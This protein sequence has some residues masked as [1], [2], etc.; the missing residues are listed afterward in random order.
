MKKIILGLICLVSF[1]F[2][3][4]CEIMTS[5]IDLNKMRVGFSTWQGQTIP[6]V[7]GKTFKYTDFLDAY[8]EFYNNMEKKANET[9]C[10]KNGWDGIAN[11]KIEWQQTDKIYNFILTGDVFTYK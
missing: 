11:F 8:S 7:D 1:S 10:K 6:I 4:K 5:P 2:A 3:E 9:I